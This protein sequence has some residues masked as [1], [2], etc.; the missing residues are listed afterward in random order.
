MTYAAL[1]QSQ[2]DFFASGATR[3]LA[4]RQQQLQTLAQA[5]QAQETAAVQALQ[6]DLGK[7]PL[8]A[9]A[10]ELLLIS[11]EI[12]WARRHLP[13]WSRPQSVPLTATQWPGRATV[14]PEPLGVSLILA[15]WNYPLQ[16]ALV[17]LIG[18]IAA[19][20]CAI[21]KPSEV[22]PH[23]AQFLQ[24]LCTQIFP[25]EY[26]QVVTGDQ[27]T[28]IALLA[29]KFDKIFFTG[30]TRVGRLV[31]Q[32]AATHLTPVT[33]ELGGK[34]PAVVAADADL[35]VAVRR[36]VWGKFLNAG[37]TCIAPDYVWVPR[38]LLP[39][40]TQQAIAVLKKFYGE[41]PQQSPDYGR[42]VSTG[43]WDRLRGLLDGVEVLW[44]GQGDR[45]QR[46]FAPTLVQVTG[47]DAPVMQEEI[48]GPILPL[49]PYDDLAA[50][51]RQLTQM[52]K[53][54]AL[55]FFGRD[56]RPWQQLCQE[57]SFGGGCFNDTIAQA[58]GPHLPFGG[59][60]ASGMGRYHG[61]HSFAAFS[62]FKSLLH[63]PN[64]PDFGLRYPPYPTDLGWLKRWL[65]G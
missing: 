40:F 46:Y 7:P 49:L 35:E 56:R 38:S 31:M 24:D 53:P 37:Q 25:P 19:G 8:E 64:R 3:P 34:S 29:E 14:L 5:L 41:N 13:R 57:V 15:P 27:E 12:A 48:F 30:S 55:Y 18:A 28:A 26:V 54:L 17:P 39:A 62:H 1:L 58:A 9:I 43:H 16:L 6:A 63:R 21:V 32:A 44:G 51:R 42:I 59:V 2:R 10:A 22:A 20:N 65:G 47:W 50:V 4:F 36:I 33:L 61:Y 52:E 23:T 11:Q 60:G 45:D